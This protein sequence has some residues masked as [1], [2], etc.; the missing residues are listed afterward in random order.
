MRR[1][2]RGGQKT[3]FMETRSGTL[4]G[5]GRGRE[6]SGKGRGKGKRRDYYTNG[7]PPRGLFPDEQGQA[8]QRGCRDHTDA[9]VP[10]SLHLEETVT[11]DVLPQER[12]QLQSTAGLVP[13]DTLSPATTRMYIILSR[14]DPSRSSRTTMQWSS[15][16][17][18]AVSS[19][20]PGQRSLRQSTSPT[21]GRGSRD[22]ARARLAALAAA[23]NARRARIFLS[24]LLS[25][26][27]PCLSSTRPVIVPLKAKIK[28][29]GC[30][31]RPKFFGIASATP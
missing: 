11:F 19:C 15:A 30:S 29:C 16:S 9:G 10:P 25:P 24:A 1:R 27:L 7:R 4:E 8:K 28:F 17:I 20:T 13:I 2:E 21:R 3:R 5:E 31:A 6:E 26:P 22:D 14:G 23:R 12:V 18:A